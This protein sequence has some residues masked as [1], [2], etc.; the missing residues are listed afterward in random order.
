[1]TATGPS[2]E[3]FRHGD[4]YEAFARC[5]LPRRPRGAVLYLHGIQ[6]HGG[7]Y[8]ASGQDLADAGFAVL[9]PDRRGSGRNR[10]DRGHVADADRWLADLAELSAELSRRTGCARIHIVGVS[11]GGKLAC[12]GAARGHAGIDPASL[13]LIAPGV[14]PKV[15]LPAVQKARVAWA[16][17]ADP[18]R[19]FEIPLDDARM[20]TAN[21]QRQAYVVGDSDRLR[22][23]SGA[24]LLH[25]RRLDR[26]ARGLPRAAWRGPVHL[27][28]AGQER[29]IDNDA[30]RRWFAELNR[31]G[32]QLSEFPDAYHT[33]EF[34]ADP[35][36]MRRIVRDWLS[37][38]EEGTVSRP[39]EA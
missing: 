5:W 23:V 16:L 10:R 39:R 18:Q 37:S 13:T 4:G 21:P 32:A 17:L 38:V 7:W 30:T 20:F 2:A 3:T 31:P 1:M 36:P 19:Q 14:F 27:L 11:W 12:A 35:R 25:S 29:I 9:M 24:F 34:E 8:E 33:L 22:T 15:D 6:S 28:L 26:V